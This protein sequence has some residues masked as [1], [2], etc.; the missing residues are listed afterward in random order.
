VLKVERIRQEILTSC[1]ITIY[2]LGI[3]AG[4]TYASIGRMMGDLHASSVGRVLKKVALENIQNRK[5]HKEIDEI[6]KIYT[7]I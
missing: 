7:E 3:D 5:T 4:M 6:R 2:L 1:K